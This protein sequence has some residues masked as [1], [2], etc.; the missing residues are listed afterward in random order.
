MVQSA[1]LP[2]LVAVQSTSLE[3]TAHLSAQAATTLTHSI[4]LDWG[5]SHN[6]SFRTTNEKYGQRLP[7]EQVLA[8]CLT[9]FASST[10][11]VLE[12]LQKGN[13]FGD[14]CKQ[15]VVVTAFCLATYA[16]EVGLCLPTI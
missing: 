8:K 12:L 9:L 4:R 5:H 11:I 1:V 6:P 13:L 7:L 3:N 10:A 14:I 16:K 2:G 15:D